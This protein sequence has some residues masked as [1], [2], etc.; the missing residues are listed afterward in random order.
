MNV[1]PSL[2]LLEQYGEVRGPACLALITSRVRRKLG[3]WWLENYVG[4]RLPQ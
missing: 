1:V 2:A 3:R 4:F